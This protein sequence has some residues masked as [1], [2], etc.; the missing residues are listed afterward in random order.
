V[1]CI[2]VRG[3]HQ[4]AKCGC[5]ENEKYGSSAVRSGNDS[6]VSAA[7]LADLNPAVEHGV[8]PHIYG[9]ATPFLP[10]GRR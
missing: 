9:L 4:M 3:S 6:T 7:Y 1:D 10:S 8:G 5:E 2:V